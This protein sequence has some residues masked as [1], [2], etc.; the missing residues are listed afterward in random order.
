LP[1]ALCLPREIAR[2]PDRKLLPAQVTN[3]AGSNITG[4][5][6]ANSR[7][8]AIPWF[9]FLEGVASFSRSTPH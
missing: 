5:G 7:T 9:I 4:K 2:E 6:V 8:G 3:C 1:A